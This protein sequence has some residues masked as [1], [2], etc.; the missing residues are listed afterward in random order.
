MADIGQTVYTVRGDDNTI[1]MWTLEAI[2]PTPEGKRAILS[3]G[4]QKCILPINCV[5]DSHKKAI[6]IA[7][8]K[9]FN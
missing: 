3:R 7:S 5:F 4:K 6:E 1:D 2:I 8:K 9:N